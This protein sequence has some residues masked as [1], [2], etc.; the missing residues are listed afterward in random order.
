MLSFIENRFYQT[1]KKKFYPM[2]E[3]KQR[4]NVTT[5]RPETL[6]DCIVH[7]AITHDFIENSTQILKSR[8]KDVSAPRTIRY[9]LE[10]L[11]IDETI[12]QFSKISEEVYRM[13]EKRRWFVK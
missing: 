8:K 3:F 2:F 7:A 1:L 4:H 6:L 5:C 12:W 10:K 13:V 11:E 9:H